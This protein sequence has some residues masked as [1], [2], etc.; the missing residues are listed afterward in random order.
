MNVFNFLRKQEAMKIENLQVGDVVIYNESDSRNNLVE[1]AAIVTALFR[2]EQ[3]TVASLVVFDSGDN[4]RKGSTRYVP[5]VSFGLNVG[6][7]KFKK[8]IKK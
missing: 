7:F 3:E 2:E 4:N 6:N 8:E 1:H 5:R